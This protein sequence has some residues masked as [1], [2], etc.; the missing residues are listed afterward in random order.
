MR[1]LLFVLILLVYSSVTFSDEKISDFSLV[2]EVDDG[3]TKIS[4]KL[5]SHMVVDINKSYSPLNFKEILIKG[6]NYRKEKG[7]PKVPVLSILFESSRELLN[8]IKISKSDKE[9]INEVNLAPY[10][11]VKCRCREDERDGGNWRGDTTDR[12]SSEDGIREPIE[13]ANT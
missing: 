5:H 10:E 9:L 7:R 12:N 1:A 11:G 6:L 13:H 2:S 3:K 4:V 8:D